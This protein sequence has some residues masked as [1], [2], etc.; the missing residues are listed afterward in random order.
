M[1]QAIQAKNG[2]RSAS[3]VQ[4]PFDETKNI[5]FFST[6]KNANV[7]VSKCSCAMFTQ[8]AQGWRQQ[9]KK[10]ATLEKYGTF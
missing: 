1:A 10:T 5:V 6:S 2:A 4:Q 7:Q 3:T 8:T 9:E